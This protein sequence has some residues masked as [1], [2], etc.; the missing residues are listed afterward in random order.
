M[1]F[2]LGAATPSLGGVC[3]PRE[4]GYLSV[5]THL[6]VT[7]RYVV[8]NGARAQYLLRCPERSPLAASPA[9]IESSGMFLR[10]SNVYWP[11]N[12]CSTS[13]LVF[14]GSRDSRPD[15]T[16][17]AGEWW[18]PDWI[19]WQEKS[20]PWKNGSAL[21]GGCRVPRKGGG[22][23]SKRV[24]SASK[25]EGPG[26]LQGRRAQ[27]QWTHARLNDPPDVVWGT[28]RWGQGAAV[29]GQWTGEHCPL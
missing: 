7:S 16:E 25:Q 27:G 23:G 21:L 1:V 22:V 24:S 19:P 10:S 8:T 28:L 13:A 29:G 14:R 17:P 4:G 11:P 20:L 9:V 3:E 15:L 12:T 18:P 6:T 26:G 2:W 5:R